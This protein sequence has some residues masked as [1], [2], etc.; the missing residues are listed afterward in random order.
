MTAAD[1]MP[2]DRNA[3]AILPGFASERYRTI[4]G[5]DLAADND[6]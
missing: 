5:N 1:D 2:A 3:F 6:R 4:L